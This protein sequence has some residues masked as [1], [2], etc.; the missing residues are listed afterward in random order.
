MPAQEGKIQLMH[1]DPDKE[2]P[3]IEPWKY[4]LVKT[5]ILS[6]VPQD[7]GG[8]AFKTLSDQVAEQLSPKALEN[9]GSVGWYTTTE[10]LDLEARGL[11]ERV[12][13]LKPQRL[14][15]L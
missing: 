15:R 6:V 4:E 12:P 14:R 7:E 5:T 2:A 8:S 13:G 1:P 9:I 10:K 3:R 11:I